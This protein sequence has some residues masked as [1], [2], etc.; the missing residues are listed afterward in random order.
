[1]VTVVIGAGARA[2][3]IVDQ[4]P[5]ALESAQMVAP[6]IESHKLGVMPVYEDMGIQLGVDPNDVT[7]A[8]FRHE[9]DI[10]RK[11]KSNIYIMTLM[12][13]LYFLQFLM[14]V[15]S[16]VFIATARS[17]LELRSCRAGAHGR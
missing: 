17:L 12:F 16:P 7:T 11:I 6:G 4:P 9:I 2:V 10:I 3:V 15:S 8:I 13:H 14:S 1:M 5:I